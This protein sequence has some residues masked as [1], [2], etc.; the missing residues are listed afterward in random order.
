MSDE[1]KVYPVPAGFAAKANLTPETYR[2]CMR[3]W[4]AF[5]AIVHPSR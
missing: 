2:G 4:K 1:N 5:Q 3:H